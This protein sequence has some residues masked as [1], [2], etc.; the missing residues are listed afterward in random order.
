[1]ARDL[2][3]FLEGLRRDNLLKTVEKEVDREW[4]ISAVC[5]H[6]FLRTNPQDRPALLFSR[7]QGSPLPVVV[8]AV[9]GSIAIYAR[10]LGIDPEHITES[11]SDKWGQAVARPLPPRWVE[12]GPCQEQIRLDTEC[13]VE[14]Y[15]NPLWTREYDPGHFFTAGCLI[16]RNPESG[17][18]N[19]GTYR[20]QVKGPR[21]LGVH[22][23]MASKHLNQHIQACRR[24][25]RSLP[26]VMAL[27]VDPALTVTSISAVPYG[28]D[29]LGVAGALLGEP[30][31]VVRARTCDLPVP[32]TAEIVIE[33]EIDPEQVSEE[34]PFGEYPGYMGPKGL[35]PD[36][37]VHCITQRKAPLLQCL[38]SQMPPSESSLMR[39]LQREAKIFSFLK[40]TLKIRIKDVH[41]PESGGGAAHLLLSIDKRYEG[42]VAQAAHGAWA[43]EPS[44]G[45][46]TIVTDADIDVRQ[47]FSREWAMAFRARPAQDIQIFRDT[48]AVGLD[49]SL[50]QPGDIKGPE[51]LSGSKVLID[52]TMKFPYPRKSLPPEEDMEKVRNSWQEYGL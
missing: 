3:A 34:G 9:G 40:D 23:T 26:I 7:V 51:Q 27:G 10:A 15:P 48:A 14:T 6:H 29:E 16:T 20:S 49:P 37:Q 21:K 18:I 52:A 45:K 35:F 47:P 32:A 38:L 8:G 44:L 4:E 24:L 30:L 33:G 22:F 17:V 13:N 46:F 50:F 19:V 31:E 11:F 43:V 5:R 12:Q 41:I 2:R 28:I 1:M 25:G 39:S 36:I 42:D